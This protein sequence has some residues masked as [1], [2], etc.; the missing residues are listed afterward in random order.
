MAV[1]P[2]RIDFAR[3]LTGLFDLQGKVAYVP[4]GYGGIGEAIAWALALAGAKVAVSGRDPRKAEAMAASLAAAGHGALGL[5]M[6]AHSVADIRSS[7][8]AVAG[9]WGRFDVLVNC[10]GI[11]KEQALLEVTEETFDEM[12]AVNLKSAMFL[13]QSAARH[14]IAGGR[15]GAQ[16]HLLSVRAQ[17]GLRGRGY[18]AYCSTKGGLV[19]LIRQHASELAP[20]GITVNGIAPTVVRTEMATHWLENPKTRAQVLDRIPLGRVADPKDVA[21][22]AL[23][24]AGPGATFITGQVL[25]IDGGITAS[26]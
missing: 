23:F 5:A 10:I 2:P 6:D 8:D 11:Q 24:F 17:L 12:L 21:G 1:I 7:V 13:A 18:S 22:A 4:G 16:V 25:Y 20:H 26:Q 19:M 14:Q 15:G 3:E 9:H